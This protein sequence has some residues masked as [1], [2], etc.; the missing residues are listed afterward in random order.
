MLCEHVI[1]FLLCCANVSIPG[2]SRYVW[3]VC[4]NVVRTLVSLA[5]PVMFSKGQN[6]EQ[7]SRIRSTFPDA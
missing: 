1:P 6:P 4:I 7:C 3:S 5:L 2:A